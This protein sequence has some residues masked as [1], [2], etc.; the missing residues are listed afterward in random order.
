MF[1]YKCTV[2][3]EHNKNVNWEADKSWWKLWSHFYFIPNH[4]PQAY[5][6]EHH[7]ALCSNSVSISYCPLHGCPMKVLPN[8]WWLF[9]D[10]LWVKNVIPT[11]VKMWA[12]LSPIRADCPYQYKENKITCAICT[13][14]LFGKWFICSL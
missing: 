7:M 9:S 12:E 10:L 5:C 1:W 4:S 11:W 6:A 13:H 14:P 8:L 2:F 3:R